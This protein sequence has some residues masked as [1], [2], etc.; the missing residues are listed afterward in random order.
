MQILI[1]PAVFLLL[2]IVGSTVALASIIGL[3]IA[4]GVQTGI[5]LLVALTAGWAIA[6]SA[7]SSPTLPLS[8]LQPSNQFS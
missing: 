7:V 4:G 5:L 6:R 8:T 1:L 2:V 3:P